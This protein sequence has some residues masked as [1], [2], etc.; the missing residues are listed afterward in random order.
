MHIFKNSRRTLLLGAM[1]TCGTMLTGVGSAWAQQGPGVT[2]KT[3]KLGAWMPLTG[4]IAAYGVPQRAGIEAYLKM[5]NDRGGIKGR[6]FELIVEDNAYNPQRTL[7]AARKLVTR[8]EVLAIVVPNGTA[9]SAATFEYMLGEAKV[10]ILNPYGGAI[11]WYSPPRDNLYG[12]LVPYE[13]QAKALGRWAAREGSRNIVVIHSALAQFEAVA[14]EVLPGA[15]GISPTA[16][17]ELYPAKFDTTDYGPIAVDIA[18][19]KPD[20]VVF[21]LAQ[22]EVVRAAKELRQQGVKSAFYTYSPN[23]SNSILELGGGAIEGLRSA[24]FTQPVTL[25]TIAM[26]EYRDALAKYSP[27]E[28]PDYVSLMGFA[29]TKI[30]V[31]A[32]NRI[33]GPIN[34]QSLTRAMESIKNYDTGIIPSVTY[35]SDR[36]LGASTVQRMEVQGGRWISVGSPID[37]LKDW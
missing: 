31:E 18:R 29:M 3:I 28:K 32:F 36:H 25:E 14:K 37:T 15:R 21:I 2:D 7:A 30:V 20:T 26:R 11:D 17:V 6:K 33:E 10:P 9:Q 24:S 4:P 27:G 1:L 13:Y 8:D 19:R 34:R 35:G 5:V 12:G 16:K 23:V 22:G